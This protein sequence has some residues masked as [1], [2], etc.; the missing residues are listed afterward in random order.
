MSQV[1]GSGSQWSPGGGG[2]MTTGG[3]AMAIASKGLI[4]GVPV[5]LTVVSLVGVGKFL[6]AARVISAAD[7]ALVRLYQTGRIPVFGGATLGPP[8]WIGPALT[9]MGG[10]ASTWFTPDSSSGGG[11][12]GEIPNLHRPPPSI[13]ETGEIL[14]NPPI[15]GEVPSSPRRSTSKKAG[16]R[17]KSCPPGYRWNGRR[18]VKKG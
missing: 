5:A 8:G 16:K 7:A 3:P 12:P 4:V 17:R 1:P 10:T 9:M 14:S 6:K 18:C 11:G 2:Y 15:A 13:E